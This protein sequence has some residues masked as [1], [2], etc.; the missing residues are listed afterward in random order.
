[1]IAKESNISRVLVVDDHPL[2]RN[3]IASLLMTNNIEVAGEANGGLEAVE[4]ARQLK[5]DV[6]LMDVR[7]P[8]C[9]GLEA[10]RLIKAEMPQTKI[11]IL[12]TSYDDEDLFKPVKTGAEGHL[13][14]IFSAEKFLTLLSAVAKGECICLAEDHRQHQ[15]Q[16]SKAKY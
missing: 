1:M 13:S 4:K 3:S 16:S 8:R 11:I 10:T 14:K 5:P 2:A 15:I 9:N 12:T 6:I 7:M